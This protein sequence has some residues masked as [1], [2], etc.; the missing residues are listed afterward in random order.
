MS[1][2]VNQN[3]ALPVDSRPRRWLARLD[4]LLIP[5]RCLVCD[6]PGWADHDLCQACAAALPW[7]RHACCRCALPLA[8]DDNAPCGRCL[9]RAPPFERTRAPFTYG[10]P[11]DRLLP[12]LKFHGD[13]ASARLLAELFVAALPPDWREHGPQALLPVPLHRARLRQRGYDQALEL[14]RLIAARTGLP[15]LASALQRTR[16]TVA[17]TELGAGARRRNVRGAF[18]LRAMALPPRVALLDDVMTTGATLGECARVLRAAGCTQVEAWCI[19]RAP[20]R[21]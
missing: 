4:A 2:P 10:F 13:L 3:P 21:R 20:L 8:A 18:V 11:L 15:L 9:R 16:A 1:A 14:A 5:P 6:E 19:A 12:R 17:Q 7:N